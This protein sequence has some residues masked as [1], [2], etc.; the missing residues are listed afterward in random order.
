MCRQSIKR[1]FHYQRQRW[2]LVGAPFEGDVDAGR[3]IARGGC[4]LEGGPQI[5]RDDGDLPEVLE[6]TCA[7]V[8]PLPCD[9]QRQ[10]CALPLATVG[11]LLHLVHIGL[12]P[13]AEFPSTVDILPQAAP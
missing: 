10:L 1:V 4:V 3:R 6:E 2:H 7:V 8:R 5:G 9:D 13:A 12:I 11:Q